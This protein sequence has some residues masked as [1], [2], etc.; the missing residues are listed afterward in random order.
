MPIPSMNLGRA[1]EAK[2]V[3][4]AITCSFSQPQDEKEGNL[5]L[6]IIIMCTDKI[7]ILF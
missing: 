6:E 5:I 1:F 2:M 4:E 3:N 7:L